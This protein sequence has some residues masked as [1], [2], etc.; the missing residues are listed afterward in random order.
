MNRDSVHFEKWDVFT[1]GKASKI[2]G[3]PR[4]KIILLVEQNIIQ[5]SVEAGGRGRARGFSRDDLVWLAI[6]AVLDAKYLLAPRALK[7]MMSAVIKKISLEGSQPPWVVEY[8][9]EEQFDVKQLTPAHVAY[10]VLG[11]HGEIGSKV[12]IFLPITQIVRDV[13]EKIESYLV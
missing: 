2:L 8:G 1:A 6:A 4:R 12:C 13:K 3:I 5:P 10:L 9:N 7:R 11:G